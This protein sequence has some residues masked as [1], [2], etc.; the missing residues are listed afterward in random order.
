MK[1]FFVGLLFFSFFANA[2][3]SSAPAVAPDLDL[4]ARYSVWLAPHQQ[5]LKPFNDYFIKNYRIDRSVEG[6]E[7]MTFSLPPDLTAGQKVEL[8]LAVVSRDGAKREFA[9]EAGKATCEGPW[10]KMTCN[11]KFNPIPHDLRASAKYLTQKYGDTPKRDAMYEI[12]SRFGGDPIG[13]AVM[14]PRD[15]R[16]FR[17]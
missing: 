3:V 4:C 6:Q 12:A 10:K 2:A 15:A 5:D 9:S 16:C 8:N 7:K 14:A 13:V 1:V 17:N 11:F